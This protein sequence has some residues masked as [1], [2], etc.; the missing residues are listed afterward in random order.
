VEAWEMSGRR[1]FWLY[2]ALIAG[3]WLVVVVWFNGPLVWGTLF[4]FFQVEMGFRLVEGI[5]RR[6][7]RVRPAPSKR[8]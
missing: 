1:W 2:A 6:P 5:R 7:T 4:A 3:L 8:L